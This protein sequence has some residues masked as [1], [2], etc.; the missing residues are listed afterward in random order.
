MLPNGVDFNVK[1][2]PSGKRNLLSKTK[3]KLLNK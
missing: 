2:M 1:I 3:Y